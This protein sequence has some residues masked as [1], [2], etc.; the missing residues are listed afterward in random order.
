MAPASPFG[1]ER[2]R[3]CFFSVDCERRNELLT[4][5]AAREIDVDVDV[6]LSVDP[7][8]EGDPFL[9]PRKKNMSRAVEVPTSTQRDAIDFTA[10]HSILYLN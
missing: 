4:D 3:N 1:L 6:A 8:A 5:R 9:Y 7:L 2:S 10:V